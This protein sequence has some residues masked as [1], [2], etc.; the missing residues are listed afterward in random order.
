M[1]ELTKT[2]VDILLIAV[3]AAHQ[4][5]EEYPHDAA[6]NGVTRERL[7]SGTF[8]LYE[9]LRQIAGELAEGKRLLT[10]NTIKE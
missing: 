4:M 9:K 3:A 8:V 10:T 6:P 5:V 2:D 1:T 7:S